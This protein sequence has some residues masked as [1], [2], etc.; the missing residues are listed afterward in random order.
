MKL[1]TILGV[2]LLC[3]FFTGCDKDDEDTPTGGNQNQT[4]NTTGYLSAKIDGAAWNPSNDSAA[5][6]MVNGEINITGI[7]SD[8]KTITITVT[9]TVPGTYDLSPGGSGAAVYQLTPTGGTN[10][11]SNFGPWNATTNYIIIASIDK[12]NKKMTGS[13][14]FKGMNTISADTVSITN[15]VFTNMPYATSVTGSGNNSFA[16]TIDSNAYNPTLIAGIVSMGN[17]N[18]VA[19]ANSGA[20]SVGLTVPANIATGTYAL[21]PFGTYTAQYNPNSTTYLLVSSGSVT[22]S[23]HNTATHKI[24]GTFYFTATDFGGGSTTANLTNGSFTIYY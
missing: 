13:F 22:I 12:I 24:V 8:G 20:Q 11:N 23:E 10:Y 1:R 2:L 17:I 14:A 6:T 21:Q 7:A 16:V 19:S 5:I 18:I 15:G 3:T 9:D 4:G